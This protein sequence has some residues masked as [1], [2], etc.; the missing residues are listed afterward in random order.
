MSL[1]YSVDGMK[2]FDQ[3]WDPLPNN[4]NMY[5]VPTAC[6]NMMAFLSEQGHPNL[7]RK[8]ASFMPGSS[9]K[10]SPQNTQYNISIMA[11]YMDT[12]P[13]DGTGNSDA[14]DGIEDFVDD[15]YFGSWYSR[16]CSNDDTIKIDHLKAH[17]ALKRIGAVCFGRYERDN[18]NNSN[19]YDRMSGHC[20]TVS[21]LKI[22]G[23]NVK[24]YYHDPA[25]GAN[26][27]L[28]TQSPVLEHSLALSNKGISVDGDWRYGIKMHTDGNLRMIDSYFIMAPM[29]MIDFNDINN[30][31]S[32]S[33]E[34]NNKGNIS[35][36][37]KTVNVKN[38]IGEVASMVTD[39]EST[40]VYL[41][42]KNKKGIWKLPLDTMEPELIN[43]VL[44]PDNIT[45]ANDGETVLFN[46]N[47][48]IFSL[49]ADKKLEEMTE[50]DVKPDALS[51][52]MKRKQLLAVSQKGSLYTIDKTKKVIK[53][54]IPTAETG[55]NRLQV[56]FDA[57]GDRL[58]TFND[59]TKSMI[60]VPLK[61]GIVAGN[62]IQPY[63]NQNQL[64]HIRPMGKTKFTAVEN[65][66][67]KF[68]DKKGSE[69]KTLWNDIPVGK[70]HIVPQK[71]NRFR[72][73]TSDLKKWKN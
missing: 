10:Y 40:V 5:C 18:P 48:K 73:E 63:Q 23:D 38:I 37:Q 58:Y 54:T 34:V 49:S 21:G 24:L 55:S 30:V 11:D 1:N 46:V 25:Q 44:Q 50:L 68:F 56:G 26:N 33:Q 66:R 8:L 36:E 51:Y 47:S 35:I 2:D 61:K 22:S 64:T 7:W 41:T 9:P 65:N 12:D 53:T 43:D 19:S 70:V 4:G 15:R 31:V 17:F 32:F 59:H 6:T 3:R 71:V 20:I 29:F 72:S 62:Y 45:V 60:W 14:L 13:Q 69:I 57:E 16:A 39:P 42:S 28:N 52:D 67:L 27:N